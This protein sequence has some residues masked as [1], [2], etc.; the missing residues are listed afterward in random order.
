MSSEDRERQVRIAWIRQR[1]T[2]QP[3]L[4]FIEIVNAYNA[5]FGTNHFSEVLGS[6]AKA[7]P[8][9]RTAK[10]FAKDVHD[11]FLGDGFLGL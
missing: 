11:V 9:K 7:L 3:K 4:S 8:P 6:Y 5:T 10:E 1:E 2:M